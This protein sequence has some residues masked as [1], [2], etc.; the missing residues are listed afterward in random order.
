MAKIRYHSLDS[1]RGIA[2]LQ[3]LIAH[4]LVAVPALAWIADPSNRSRGFSFFITHSP[5]SFFWCDSRA[6]KVFFVLSGFVLSLPYFETNKRNSYLS[7]FVKRIIRLYLP[8]FAVIIISIALQNILYQ[9]NTVNM[10]GGWV[11][12]MWDLPLNKESSQVFFLNTKYLDH[13]DRALWSLGPEIKLSLVLPFFIF[14]IKK[15]NV[16]LS[17]AAI[18]LYIIIYHCLIKLQVHYIWTDFPTFFFLSFFLM[19]TV[20]C[21]YK[22]SIIIFMDALANW[23]YLLLLFI[24]LIIYTYNYT[25]WFMPYKIMSKLTLMDDYI[26]G[27]A[28]VLLLAI[29]ISKRAH[30]L[31]NTKLLLFLGKISFSIYLIHILVITVAAYLLKSYFNP[32]LIVCIA[33]VGSFPLAYF[34][35]RSVEMPSLKLANEIAAFMNNKRLKMQVGK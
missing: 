20:M 7:F 6:V 31:L 22:Q 32:I 12:M 5:L 11:K 34:F 4:S 18:F 15:L 1:L 24:S 33:F 9:S 14:I 17:I 3:V 8:C 29:T 26:S 27:F 30:R 19:G 10:F 13:F 28:A 21:K 25:L 2:S 23:Q 35:Y 16:Y